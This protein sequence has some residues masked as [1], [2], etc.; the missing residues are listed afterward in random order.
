MITKQQWCYQFINPK[1]YFL[2]TYPHTCQQSPHMPTPHKDLCQPGRYFARTHTYNLSYVLKIFTQR[3]KDLKEISSRKGGRELER[4][5]ISDFLNLHFCRK[6]E[7]FLSSIGTKETCELSSRDGQPAGR[8]WS[9][10]LLYIPAFHYSSHTSQPGFPCVCPHSCL[11]LWC[12]LLD[13]PKWWWENTS[14]RPKAPRIKSGPLQGPS[15]RG[16]PMLSHRGLHLTPTLR[17]T[18]PHCVIRGQL[19]PEPWHSPS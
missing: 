5:T 15:H 17:E 18:R 7:M 14:L 6:C 11:P 8:A 16:E 13:V 19:T 3:G 2:E 9:Q 1:Y 4:H 10:W 12:Q